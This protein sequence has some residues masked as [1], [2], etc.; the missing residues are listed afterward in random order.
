MNERMDG[1]IPFGDGTFF[2][3]ITPEGYVEGPCML[4][5]KN[6]YYFMWSQGDWM[7]G[8]YC[9]AYGIA[10][11]PAEQVNP[12]GKNLFSQPNI[13]SVPGHHGYLQILGT[14]E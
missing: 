2:R 12:L 5:R 13:A 9:V 8:S 1:F 6:P 7:D 10:E 3:E 4:K 14:D 11:Y